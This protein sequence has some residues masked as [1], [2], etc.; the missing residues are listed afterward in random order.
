MKKFVSLVTLIAIA[1]TCANAQFNPNKLLQ[2]AAQGAIKQATQKNDNNSK[3][4]NQP[5]N[6][7]TETHQTTENNDV[8][9]QKNDEQEKK[10]K[11]IEAEEARLDALHY[12][13]RN[14]PAFS[15]TSKEATWEFIRK[16]PIKYPRTEFYSQGWD[17]YQAEGTFAVFEY[18]DDYVMPKSF[19]K[20]P[21]NI[22]LRELQMNYR[23]LDITDLMK[24]M[25]FGLYEVSNRNPH[26]VFYD[27][28]CYAS[29]ELMDYLLNELKNNGFTPTRRPSAYK[30]DEMAKG[31]DYEWK[32]F[33]NDYYAYMTC[34]KSL[35]NDNEYLYWLV[36]VPNNK[37]DEE[38]FDG[39][40][41]PTEGYP[42]GD[43]WG[44]SVWEHKGGDN[45]EYNADAY[46]DVNNKPANIHWDRYDFE[47]SAFTPKGFDKYCARLEK[48]GFTIK[49]KRYEDIEDFTISVTYTKGEYV[50]S[51]T[52]YRDEHKL[53]LNATDFELLSNGW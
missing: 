13:Q 23:P 25:R 43:D 48:A 42:E 31:S 40:P 33:S 2:K 7:T 21:E 14:D 9:K 5:K 44:A 32:M 11:L 16:S 28:G 17:Y 20:K 37:A 8:A 39:V 4:N 45:W 34:R 53:I 35:A 24:D 22:K 29:I 1:T 19:P 26:L 15:R 50:V 10:L 41:M 3:Q 52:L 6:E 36:F 12:N 51:L 30:L 46:F 27:M 18:W 49:D 38:S 47:Y